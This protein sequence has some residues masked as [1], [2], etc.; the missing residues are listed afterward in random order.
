MGHT[1]IERERGGRKGKRRG[2]SSE[3]GER[4]V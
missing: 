1:R 2:I 4:K 3:E